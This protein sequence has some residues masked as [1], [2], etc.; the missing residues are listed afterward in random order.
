MRHRGKPGYC[1][2]IPG[3]ELMDCSVYDLKL[4]KEFLALYDDGSLGFAR[5]R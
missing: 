4:G 5:K 3:K 2:V 1:A